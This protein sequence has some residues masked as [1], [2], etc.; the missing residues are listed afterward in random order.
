[1]N[2]HDARD[3]Q[4]SLRCLL[5]PWRTGGSVG[6]TIYVVLGAGGQEHARDDEHDVVIGLM[7]TAQLAEGAVVAHNDWL[8]KHKRKAGC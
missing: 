8:K 6:R 3:G 4:E 7:D 5:H 2:Q 1:V